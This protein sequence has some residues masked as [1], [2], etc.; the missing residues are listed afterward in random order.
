MRMRSKD[1]KQCRD[2]HFT[3][4]AAAPAAGRRATGHAVQV[5]RTCRNC[6]CCRLVSVALCCLDLLLRQLF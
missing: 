4:E 1:F 3:A 6:C 5:T 2:G